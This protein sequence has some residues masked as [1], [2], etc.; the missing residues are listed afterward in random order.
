MEEGRKFGIADGMILIAGIAAGMAMIRLLAPVVSWEQVWGAFVT[1]SQGWSLSYALGLFVEL[2][3]MFGIPVL[4]AWTPACLLVQVLKPRPAWRRLRR[5]PGFIACLSS[6]VV[7]A[8]A[9]A[10]TTT[11]VL[12]QFFVPVAPD[13]YVKPALLGG[14]VAGSGVLWLWAAMWFWGVWHARPT[15]VDRLGR[16]TGIAWVI[17]GAISLVLFGMAF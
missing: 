13:A 5:R 4:A 6:T 8:G 17:V 15:W 11:C 3:V 10:V 16:L 14:C 1:P 9:V 12:L 2:G 7:V